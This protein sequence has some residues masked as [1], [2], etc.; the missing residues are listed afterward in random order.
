MCPSRGLI[1]FLNVHFKGSHT[2]IT[3]LYWST[4]IAC[5]VC[6]D[7]R[8]LYHHC[9]LFQALVC[10]RLDCLQAT[11]IKPCHRSAYCDQQLNS[12]TVML[13]S[14]TV[15]QAHVQISVDLESEELASV[16]KGSLFGEVSTAHD[17]YA[18]EKWQQTCTICFEIFIANR[19]NIAYS[20]RHLM[21]IWL[22]RMLSVKLTSH[23]L[24][25]GHSTAWPILIFCIAWALSGASKE[26]QTEVKKYQWKKI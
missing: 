18:S 22:W 11:T 19:D 10:L 7:C 14:I 25:S 26:W 4:E 2:H 6:G 13:A 3:A 12:F 21:T 9:Q 24:P 1:L 23:Y 15:S 8:S 20:M 16:C 5:L 17:I